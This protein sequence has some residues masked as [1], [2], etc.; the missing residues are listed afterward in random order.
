MAT[1]ATAVARILRTLNRPSTETD[2][3]QGA[4][5]AINDAVKQLQRDHAYVYTEGLVQVTYP[6]NELFI[7]LGT[8]C[9][10]TVRDFLSVQQVTSETGIQGKP[11]RLITY[12]QLQTDR[13]NYYKR[14]AVEDGV[15][16]SA[17]QPGRTIEDGYRSDLTVFIANQYLG[18]YPRQTEA[19]N[20]LI[21]LHTW[22]PEFNADGDTN[23]FLDVAY[24]LVIMM[25]LK[26]MSFFMKSDSRLNIDN[27][28]ISVRVKSL[29]DWD[30][31]LRETPNGSLE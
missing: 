7:D 2:I 3:V 14:H 20:L 21:N 25:A 27:A 31:Q 15:D 5:D 23:F 19:K 26:N 10:G 9:D 28:E 11:L 17:N 12:S 1:F 6:A 18:L 16:F 24:D 30:S 22:L 8:V 13:R 29:M 4:K